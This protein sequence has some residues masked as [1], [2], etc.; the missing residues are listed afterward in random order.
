MLLKV[1]DWLDAVFRHLA[2]EIGD[3]DGEYADEDDMNI[4]NESE[5]CIEIEGDSSLKILIVEDDFICRKLMLALMSEFGDCAI[6]VNG[7]EAVEAV[8][9]ALDESVP[10]D[11]VC[12]DI[13]MPEMDG[14]EALK[15]IREIEKERGIEGLDGVKVIMTTALGDSKNV[16]GAFRTGC[17]AY[18][19]KPVR[20]GK[21][22]QEMGKLGLVKVSE[23][24]SVQ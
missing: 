12:L 17:E 6:A 21:L 15:I 20:K 22:I 1:K 10:Y 3:V 9:Y 16:I 24:C 2:S 8:K 18:I 4:E 13:M 5:E 11:L 14:H 23:N 7:Q 19:V